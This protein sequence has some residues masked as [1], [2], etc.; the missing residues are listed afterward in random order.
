[1]KSKLLIVSLS[2]LCSLAQAHP[3]QNS[4]DCI[5]MKGATVGAYALNMLP[6]GHTYGNTLYWFRTYEL[7]NNNAHQVANGFEKRVI[8]A[9]QSEFLKSALQEIV[10]D[11]RKPKLSGTGGERSWLN[12]VVELS[13]M[14]NRV[15]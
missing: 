4:N 12:G 2:L 7:V 9:A 11:I 1:M 5:L 8:P 13:D 3:E 10:D 6:E 15:I 14:S